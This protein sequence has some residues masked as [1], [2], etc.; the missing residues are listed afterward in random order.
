[1]QKVIQVAREPLLVEGKRL[2]RLLQ[3]SNT[4]LAPLADPLLEDFGAHRGLK[5]GREEAYSAWPIWIV[6]KT[7]DAGACVSPVWDR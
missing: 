2:R 3:R 4:L 1:V 7:T 5:G 6:E